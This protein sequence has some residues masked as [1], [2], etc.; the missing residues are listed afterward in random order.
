M[1]RTRSMH[2]IEAEVEVFFRLPDMP[3]DEREVA[4]PTIKIDY[5][6]LPGAPEQGPTYACGGQP[7]DPD[8]VEL[9]RAVLV[10]GDGLAPTQEQIDEWAQNWL[11]DKGYDRAIENAMDERDQRETP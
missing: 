7:A 4:Y 8:E 6:W 3:A 9:M 10:N 5:T 11:D 1:R 2:T